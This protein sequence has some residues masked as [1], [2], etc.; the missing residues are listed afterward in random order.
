MAADLLG[1]TQTVPQW[2]RQK[3]PFH[4][5]DVF[6]RRLCA[7]PFPSQDKGEARSLP[8]AMVSNIHKRY[9]RDGLTWVYRGKVFMGGWGGGTQ[10]RRVSAAWR[11]RNM[12][13]IR[14]PDSCL[15]FTSSR[16]GAFTRTRFNS[17]KRAHCYARLS[18]SL[19]TITFERPA[20]RSV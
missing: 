20:E 5:N 4:L 15:T 17:H 2:W 13:I 12:P 19:C 7:R 16:S 6:G 9:R 1:V 8:P 18:R 14:S 3:G 11:H 10:H